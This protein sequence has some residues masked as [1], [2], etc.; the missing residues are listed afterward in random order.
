MQTKPIIRNGRDAAMFEFLF[1]NLQDP[2]V[3]RVGDIGP[4][5]RVVNPTKL[6]EAEFPNDPD[7][8]EFVF[9]LVGVGLLVRHKRNSKSPIQST[10]EA[11]YTY[12][13]PQ[14]LW[15]RA[16]DL[17]SQK[18]NEECAASAEFVPIT[19]E[20]ESVPSP[21]PSETRLVQA[22]VLLNRE[23]TELIT[24]RESH[25]HHQARLTTEREQSVLRLAEIEAE[26]ASSSAAL[27]EIDQLLS[28]AVSFRV[29]AAKFLP[30]PSTALAATK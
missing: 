3:T 30:S 27:A 10:E 18:L 26:I 9:H 17:L 15:Y 2:V 14:V 29:R 22:T 4:D 24:A 5:Q 20:P 16:I 11:G 8:E 23:E 13:A 1:D 28:E 12:H 6:L 25:A 19:P 21:T 7:P